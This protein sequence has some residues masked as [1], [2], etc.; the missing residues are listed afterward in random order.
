MRTSAFLI[1]A[2]ALFAAGAQAQSSITIY[3]SV[4]AGV[5]SI[6]DERGARNTKVDTGNRSPNRI[7]FRGSEDLG[8]GVRA[9]FTLEGGYNLDD[10]SLKR[11]NTLFNRAA[12][13]GLSGSAGTLS[14]GHIPDFMYDYLRYTGGGSLA[15]LYFFHPANLDN[16]ANQF[17][18]DN[19]IKYESPTIAGF[20]LGAMNGFGERG[21]GFNRGRSYS[22]GLRYTGGALNG[23]AAYTVSNDRALNLGNGLGLD[24][25]L[26]QALSADAAAPGAS[27]TSFDAERVRSAGV[28]A[29]Y[30]MG[31]FRPSV[32]A[33]RI[34]LQAGGAS[35]TMR[36]FEL[37]TRVE[38]VKSNTLVL[39]MTTSK[40]DQYR[41]HQFNIAD[42]VALSPRTVVYAAAAFQR[43]SGDGAH[44]VIHGV[45][46]ASGKS[47]RVLRI[48]IDHS[49]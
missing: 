3:G 27:Y 6:N 34:E 5:S 20:T 7:G 17:Q 14:A 49:F 16:Q 47:Q 46:P 4:D 26:G 11:P 37:G 9:L 23:A 30:R 31:R 40:L 22:L 42:L 24:S 41:W 13:V 15:S 44:A 8:N 43:A 36:N 28:S 19:A 2:L 39:S 1:P 10:G 32:M 12:W 29:A 18:I 35:A 21:D 45:G 38:L 25:L 33:T 48:G